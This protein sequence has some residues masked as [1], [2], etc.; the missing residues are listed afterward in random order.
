MITMRKLLLSLTVLGF[1]ALAFVPSARAD[2]TSVTYNFD[3]CHLTGGCGGTGPYGSVTLTDN[4]SGG[5]D[6]TVTLFNSND[7]FVA[8]G[9]GGGYYFK[10]VG[11]ANSTSTY[12]GSLSSSSDFT[13]L[14]TGLTANGPGQY[15]G[16]GTGYFAFGITCASCGTG[17]NPYNSNTLT[18][19]VNNAT[20]SDLTVANGLGITFV[21]DVY[22]ANIGQT[23]PIDAEVPV[24]EPASLLLIGTGLLGLGGLG[25]RRKNARK[26]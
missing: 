22:L 11:L 12:S 15:D 23:G 6:V 19:T 26:E 20:I 10:L 14:G 17:N 13:S 3:S 24:P 4:G 25:L 5:V 8:T 1:F 9:A 7:Y 16:D 21:A 18:F 2:A